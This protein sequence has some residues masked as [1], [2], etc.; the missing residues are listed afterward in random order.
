MDI[1]EPKITKEDILLL[2]DSH[3][4]SNNVCIV[5]GAASGIGR[6]TAVAAAANKLMTVGLDIDEGGGKETQKMAREMGGQMI[7]IRTDLCEDQQIDYAVSE[8]ARLG[9]I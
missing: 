9:T 2:D 3:F 8:A 1:Q 6:A 7:F 5:T 4:N